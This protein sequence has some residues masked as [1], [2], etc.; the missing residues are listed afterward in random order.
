MGNINGG[1]YFFTS[2]WH[3]GEQQT[4]NTHSY[5]RPRPTEQMVLEWLEDVRAKVTPE[6]T[7]VFV[8]DL[9]IQL[10]DYDFYTR[11][12]KCN[13]ILILG[14]KEYNNKHFTKEELLNYLA[15]NDIFH[16]VYDFGNF[17]IDGVVYFVSHKPSDAFISDK[18]AICGHIHGIWRLATLPTGQPIINVGIDVWGGVVSEDFIIHQHRAHG[19]YDAE[20]FPAKWAKNE[21]TD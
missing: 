2:D 14:D 10:T 9:G 15:D 11:L 17:E 1:K 4:P 21:K 13:K 7:L 18:P 3:N 16:E 8:G 19:M 12:P 20:A 5:L 6:D